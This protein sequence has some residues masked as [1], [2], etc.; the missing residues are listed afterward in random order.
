MSREGISAS[1]DYVQKVSDFQTFRRVKDV[2]SFLGLSGYYRAYIRNYAVR[3]APM[4]VCIERCKAD[5]RQLLNED[6]NAACE[7]ARLDLVRCLQSAVD[8]PLAYP[9]F[10]Q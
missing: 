4:R 3:S 7:A 6:W 8:G 5:N 9:N 2:Q 1:P 10:A